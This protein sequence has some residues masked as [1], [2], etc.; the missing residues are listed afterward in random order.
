MTSSD[1]HPD[2]HHP[3]PDP[4]HHTDHHPNPDHQ[5]DPNP[6]HHPTPNPDKVAGGFSSEADAEAV[7]AFFAE[8]PTKVAI[9]EPTPTPT[10]E[11]EKTVAQAVEAI[12]AQASWRVRDD[13]G[14]K[15]WA[16]SR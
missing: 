1:H 10:K 13:A 8:H 9:V 15:A 16:A 6:G 4:D 12:R 7:L 14:V 5:P 11:L 2:H 3:S